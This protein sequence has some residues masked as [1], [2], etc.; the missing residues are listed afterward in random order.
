MNVYDASINGRLP[1]VDDVFGLSGPKTSTTFHWNGGPVIDEPNDDPDTDTFRQLSIDA[2]LHISKGWG[3]IS[4]HDAIARS[5]LLVH[6]RNSLAVL[7]AVANADGNENSRMVQ[8]MV[9][10]GQVPTPEQ[11]VTM[12]EVAL[13]APNGTVWGHRDWSPTECPGAETYA[14]IQRRAWETTQ[15]DDMTD[16][17]R[18]ILAKLAERP[19]VVTAIVE[20][21]NTVRYILHGANDQGPG[22][23]GDTLERVAALEGHTAIP[24]APVPAPV[25]P[26]PPI[27]TPG[28]GPQ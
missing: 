16:A 12:A 5:G 13:D 20:G 18:A 7:A 14:W 1:F 9:G 22:S 2:N 23:Y 10:T 19:D 25:S 3:G 6:C 27:Y 24:S 26:M 4:Y 17:E 21:G 28:H 8:V 11:W 15:E